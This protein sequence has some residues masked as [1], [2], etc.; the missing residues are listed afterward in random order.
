MSDKTAQ[1]EADRWKQ[2]YY[3]QLDVLER[4]Q[5]DW[6]DLEAIL[7]KAVLKLSIAAEG[8]HATIDR[9]LRDIRPL[10]KQQVDVRRLEQLLDDVSALLLKLG[11]R[12]AKAQNDII[13]S[14]VSLLE[15]IDF[16]ASA[17]KQK[18]KLL[19][20]LAGAT[21]DDGAALT[22]RGAWFPRGCYTAWG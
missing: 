17:S 10:V 11:D 2:Q 14:L 5:K 15:A 6:Q 7:K 8:Q 18:N 4:K 20:K 21:A 9:H 3:E 12:Q 16:P 13:G 1:Q 22:Y 19:K